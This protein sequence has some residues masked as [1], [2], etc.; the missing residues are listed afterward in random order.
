M[1]NVDAESH[2]LFAGLLLHAVGKD[3]S[4]EWGNAPDIDMGFLHRYW[5][6][7][8]NTMPK[9]Y[10]EFPS[11]WKNDVDKLPTDDRD[12]VALCIAAHDYLDIFNGT[13]YCFGFWHPIYPKKTVIVHV[14]ED[15]DKP[16][17][18]VKEIERLAGE[19]SYPKQ[20]YNES[21]A[22]ME[23][24]V[25]PE[26]KIEE[27]TAQIVLRLAWHAGDEAA[28]N[29]SENSYIYRK[30]MQDIATFTGNPRYLQGAIYLRN[31]HSICTQFEV[32]YCKLINKGLDN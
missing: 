31:T 10:A 5:R 16:K 19:E 24:L 13:L 12:A 4:P 20:F 18:L 23:I 30:A 25:I 2:T 14:L 6:H 29:P 11:K 9:I 28:M 21:I 22:V 27:L 17:E 15:I 1:I 26:I 32:E 3:I 8:F 7:R